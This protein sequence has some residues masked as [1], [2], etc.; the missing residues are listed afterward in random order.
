M[1]QLKRCDILLGVVVLPLSAAKA[2]ELN[3]YPVK[4]V[5]ADDATHFR[6]SPLKVSA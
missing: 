5:L 2:S 3:A 4:V 6:P 1:P